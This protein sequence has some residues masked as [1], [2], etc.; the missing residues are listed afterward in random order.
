MMRKVMFRFVDRYAK[1]GAL[2]LDYAVVRAG[3]DE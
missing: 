1:S 3:S 2:T